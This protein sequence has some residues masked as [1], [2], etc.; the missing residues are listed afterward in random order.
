MSLFLRFI[1][2]VLHIDTHLAALIAYT[3]SWSYLLLF[4]IIFCE[5]GLVVTP[6]L[7]GDSLLFAAGALA[8]QEAFHIG[9]LLALLIV[10]A[11]LGDTVNYWI[12][13]KLGHAILQSPSPWLR[14]KPAHLEKTQRFFHTYGSKAIVMARF[15]P[16]VR[17]LAPF[18]AG[19]GNM[20]YGTFITY[21]IVGGISWV[22]LL[23]L[24]GY[25]FGNVPFVKEHFSVII[26]AIILISLTPLLIEYLRSRM[27]RTKKSL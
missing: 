22:G 24:L 23:L 18:M 15:A 14:I 9:W 13:R 26:I 21:N 11:I 5:T 16:I 6:F 1:D 8:A 27:E 20:E 7:P 3:G 12:G 10:A 2:L 25:F 19:V 4:L 17:T